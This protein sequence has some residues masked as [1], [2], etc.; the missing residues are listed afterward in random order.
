MGSAGLV[1]LRYGRSRRPALPTIGTTFVKVSNSRQRS[2]FRWHSKGAS[3]RTLQL[4]LLYQTQRLRLLHWNLWR[5]L[6]NCH[7][8]SE[9]TEESKRAV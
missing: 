3:R 6:H 5:I 2:S 7:W 4:R 8:G 1:A 9:T